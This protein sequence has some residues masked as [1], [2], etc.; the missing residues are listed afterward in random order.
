MRWTQHRQ[1][2]AGDYEQICLPSKLQNEDPLN[3][4][5]TVSIDR[6]TQTTDGQK[7]IDR[8]TDIDTETVRNPDR[9]TDTLYLNR[10]VGLL[11]IRKSLELGF[12]VYEPLSYYCQP[13]VGSKP[14]CVLGEWAF[15]SLTLNWKCK[16]CICSICSITCFTSLSTVIRTYLLKMKNQSQATF[17]LWV[18]DSLRIGP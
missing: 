5:R 8:Q 11:L 12:V 7:Q 15:G 13:P 17:P 14:T 3:L 10:S 16:L 2:F 1:V 9:W 18:M 6:H 4:T